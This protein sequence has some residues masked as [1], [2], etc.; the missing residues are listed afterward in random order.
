MQTLKDEYRALVVGATGGIGAALTAALENDP[1]CGAVAT[2]DRRQPGFDITDEAAIEAQA[3]ALAAAHGAF[4]LIIVA[5]GALTIDGVGP[6]KALRR[7]DPAIMARAFAVNT[8]GPALIIKHFSPLLAGERS[9][10][11]C[12]SARVGSIASAA[13]CP[14]APPRRR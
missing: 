10:L 7:L 11:A 2:L 6:E 13:G 5:T 12:L 1:R 9:L 8:I 14:T 3:A 4:D